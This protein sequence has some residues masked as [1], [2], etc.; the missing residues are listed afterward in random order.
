MLHNVTTQGKI[1]EPALLPEDTPNSNV[2]DENITPPRQW[3][4]V[5]SSGIEIDRISREITG[6]WMVVF[7]VS[8]TVLGGQGH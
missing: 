3:T 5:D 2:K 4:L 6:L 8:I 1:L 7:A